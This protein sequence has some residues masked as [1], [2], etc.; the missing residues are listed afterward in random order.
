MNAI[1]GGWLL[2]RRR[3]DGALFVSRDLPDGWILIRRFE[4][5]EA[6]FAALNRS[7]KAV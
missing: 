5:R 4:S 1:E 7:T 2:V 3:V 6:A